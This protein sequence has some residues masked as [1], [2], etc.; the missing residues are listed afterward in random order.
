MLGGRCVKRVSDEECP[1]Q[2]IYSCLFQ[3]LQET[4]K[5]GTRRDLRISTLIS[6]TLISTMHNRFWLTQTLNYLCKSVFIIIVYMVIIV[7]IRFKVKLWFLEI[8]V[9]LL[10]WLV[11]FKDPFSCL[12]QI[13]SLNIITLPPPGI[14]GTSEMSQKIPKSMWTATRRPERWFGA[15][16]FYCVLNAFSEKEKQQQKKT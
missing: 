7:T 4:R 8:K 3:R 13:I 12:I 9:Y 15:W 6:T 14:K 16:L 1:L 2:E 5:S 11:S 10:V